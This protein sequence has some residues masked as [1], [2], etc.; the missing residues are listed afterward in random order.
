MGRIHVAALVDPSVKNERIFAYGEPY[1]WNQILSIFRKLFP[2]RTFVEDL[3]DQ[4]KDLSTVSNERAK[5]IL[6][7]F[8]AHGFTELEQSLKWTVE[9]LA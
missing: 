3:A 9:S 6:Q 8:G 2:D 1:T 7:R 4:G 5:E